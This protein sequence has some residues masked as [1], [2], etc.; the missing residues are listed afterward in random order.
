[1][2]TGFGSWFGP[3]L[4]SSWAASHAQPHTAAVFTLATGRQD[5]KLGVS[6]DHPPSPAITGQTSETTP[7]SADSAD[8]RRMTH[9]REPRSCRHCS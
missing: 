4:A 8:A 9:G 2:R 7:T 5:S 1:M 6:S 3:D